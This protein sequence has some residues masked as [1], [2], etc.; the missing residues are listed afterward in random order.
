MPNGEEEG[1]GEETRREEEREKK[2]DERAEERGKCEGR[3][4]G[5]TEEKQEGLVEWKGVKKSK[6]S[7][8]RKETLKQ[9]TGEDVASDVGQKSQS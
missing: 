1:W 7:T 8:E 9:I 4:G 5:H 2:V 6:G 3:E